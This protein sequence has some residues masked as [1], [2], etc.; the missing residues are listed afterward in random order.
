M[1]ATASWEGGGSGVNGVLGSGAGEC[2]STRGCPALEIKDSRACAPW[3]RR[4]LA[5]GAGAVAVGAR[6]PAWGRGLFR[7]RV[8]EVGERGAREEGA[9]VA[10]AELDQEDHWINRRARAHQRR[11][12]A[13]WRQRAAGWQHARHED[14]AE[15]G[16]ELNGKNGGKDTVGG[17]VDDDFAWFS[18]A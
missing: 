12:C 9:E 14:E 17:G 5:A 15:D 4:R 3:R 8:A 7:Y 6:A 16:E 2:A 13:G 1:G 18:P 10:G 11:R